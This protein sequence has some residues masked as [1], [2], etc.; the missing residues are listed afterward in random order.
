ML[1]LN[2]GLSQKTGKTDSPPCNASTNLEVELDPDLIN[3]PDLLQE[4]AGLRT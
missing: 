2:V 4:H 3:E 1:K